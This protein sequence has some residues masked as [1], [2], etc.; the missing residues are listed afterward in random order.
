MDLRGHLRVGNL[1]T[2]I[3]AAGL[4]GL[5]SC[6]NIEGSGQYVREVI[7]FLGGPEQPRSQNFRNPEGIKGQS[8][9]LLGKPAGVPILPGKER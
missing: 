2:L 9:E 1:A 5:A 6:G 8:Q 7:T 3:A 4:V